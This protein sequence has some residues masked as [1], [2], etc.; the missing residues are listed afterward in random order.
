M[1]EYLGP[2]LT[3]KQSIESTLIVR[4]K[5][6]IEETL[7]ATNEELLQEKLIIAQKEGWEFTKKNK[8]SIRISKAK[9]L[10]EQLEDEI[11]SIL[12]QMQFDD[13]SDGRNFK[14]QTDE[15]LGPRQI[16][17]FA[18]D[19]EVVIFVECT[20]KETLGPKNMDHL[21]DKITSF[22]EKILQSVSKHYGRESR[23][24][25]GW[26]IAT[27]NILWSDPDIEK[28][29]IAKIHIF[30]ERQIDYYKKITQIYKLGAKYQLLS[31][32]FSN[33]KI[34]GLELIVPATKGKMGDVK[35]YNFLINPLELIKIA[36]VSHKASRDVEDIETYQ[37]LLN[38]KRLKEIASYIDN[39]GQ[40]PTNIV[41]NIRTGKKGL[42][43]E[44]ID[45]VGGSSF[46]RLHLP[47]QYG[48]AMI[49]DGQHRLF[50][51]TFSDKTLK[52]KFSNATIPVLAYENLSPS[53]EAQLFIDINCEQVRIDR[54]LINEIQSELYWDSDDHDLQLEALRSKVVMMLNNST[55]SPFYE[56]IKLTNKENS[57]K[58]CLTL[59]NFTDGLKDNKFFGETS[60]KG[61][62][63]GHLS[64][65][66]TPDLSNSSAKAFDII[67]GFFNIFAK[68]SMYHWDLGNI[69]NE[70]TSQIGYLSTN[71][72]VR[73]L[74]IV[75]KHI[76][77]HIKSTCA[78]DTTYLDSSDI[79]P[80]IESF[81]L[82][83]AEIFEM[84]K[85]DV[86][87]QFRARSGGKKGVS[88]N[89]RFLEAII[90]RQINSF[91]PPGLNEFLENMDV[92]GT[93]DAK[94]LIGQMVIKMH[95]FVVLK[96]KE[97]FPGS[98]E[99]KYL[100][101]WYEGV[102]D[103]VRSECVR[104]SD[105]NKG[106]NEPEQYLDI[107]DYQSIA[108]KNWRGCFE[109]YFSFTKEG[110]KENKL[111]WIAELN[112]IRNITHHENKWP[113]TKDQVEFVRKY[114]KLVME[115][116]VTT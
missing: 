115:R 45:D 98:A 12:A 37:R 75:L 60:A 15:S 41:L 83:I 38:P 31:H 103:P 72:G 95:D 77:D 102:P 26:V 112:T 34:Q 28:A 99:R 7:K 10:D 19:E 52:S 44:K 105:K 73:A 88:I 4:K 50:G 43:F 101:W 3:D 100:E 79:L 66:S 49:I 109:E 94:E 68:K 82:P 76:L 17:V 85:F 27:R 93:K 9:P 71:E 90:N 78:I 11:W 42:V 35:F 14:I 6:V 74:L 8:A 110:G 51:Y 47:S 63:P 97:K 87:N 64:A 54:N 48:S 84:S 92:E 111:A 55:K 39:G 104:L 108:A 18:K 36:H 46:G 116:F 1:S 20:R 106:V 80:K 32:I 57:Y 114:H 2:L 91:S 13:L 62:I 30:T 61:F 58:R 81:A 69:K 33:E 86:I 22:R 29:K 65:S 25:Y 59:N 24:K 5:K 53:R 16:D 113:A 40:F 67:T 21:I 23:L 89:A 96:L 56:R 70:K 107:V